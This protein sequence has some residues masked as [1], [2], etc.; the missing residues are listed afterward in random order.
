M[1]TVP[2]PASEPVDE[3]ATDLPADTAPTSVSVD[4]PDSAL[5]L[6]PSEPTP[7][8][9]NP[10]NMADTK[11]QTETSEESTPGAAEY[12]KS[13]YRRMDNGSN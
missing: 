1:E 10:A 3:P 9:D 2:E 12:M 7:S 11:N 5:E 4:T 6:F 8:G 13:L